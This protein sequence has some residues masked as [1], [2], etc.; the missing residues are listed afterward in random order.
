[1]GYRAR[2][3]TKKRAGRFAQPKIIEPFGRGIARYERADERGLS[4][5]DAATR[6]F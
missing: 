3:L 2:A 6:R 4:L 5:I 1:L